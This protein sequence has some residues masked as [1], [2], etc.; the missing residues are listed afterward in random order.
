MISLTKYR[1]SFQFWFDAGRDASEMFR[2]IGHSHEAEEMM[3]NFLI[4]VLQ[5]GPRPPV[6]EVADSGMSANSLARDEDATDV[7]EDD[8]S[9]AFVLDEPPITPDNYLKSLLSN[10]SELINDEQLASTAA[11]L[12]VELTEPSD[13]EG[14]SID[15]VSAPVNIEDFCSI[16]MTS[17][18]ESSSVVNRK[19]AV[20]VIPPK[21]SLD[22][23][24]IIEALQQWTLEAIDSMVNIFVTLD[25]F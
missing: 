24:K 8:E 20:N 1:A 11:L 17:A 22:R 2:D 21:S 13:P 18:D 25:F 14:S 16:Y 4:G 15:D 9:G 12:E 6:E 10:V 5:P 7:E 19:K 23:Q 3:S